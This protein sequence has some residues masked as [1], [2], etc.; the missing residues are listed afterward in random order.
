MHSR[1]ALSQSVPS[2]CPSLRCVCAL[3]TTHLCF[4]SVSCALLSHSYP[5]DIFFPCPHFFVVFASFLFF[6]L[7]LELLCRCSSDVL[8]SSKPRMYVSDYWQSAYFTGCD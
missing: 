5:D 4:I 3:C 7:S 8:L 6:I 1:L 2:E